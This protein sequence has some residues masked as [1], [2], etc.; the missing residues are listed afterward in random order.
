M[1]TVLPYIILLVSFVGLVLFLKG[2]SYKQIFLL[3]L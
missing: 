1:D 3:V 2:F